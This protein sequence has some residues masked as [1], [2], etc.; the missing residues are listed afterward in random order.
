MAFFSYDASL[1][2]HIELALSP[3][4]LSNYKNAVGGDL[5]RA[6]DLYCWNVA[7]GAA[8]FG[9]L[10][11]LEV[12][13]LNALDL[14]L[15]T[16]FSEPWYDDPTFRVVDA[17]MNSRID[18]AKSEIL[19]RGRTVT[20]SRVI[21]ELSFGFWV[22]MLRPGPKGA[23]VRTLWGPAISR[24][25]PRGLNRANVLLLFD[26]LLRFR[27]RVAHHEP[28]FASDLNAQYAGVLAAINLLAPA[29][30]PWVEHHARVHEL[31]ISGPWPALARY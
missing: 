11:V 24:A 15:S 9:P 25:F 10:G 14:Q 28:I 29:L 4:R 19:K 6:V 16:V 26:P 12:V 13:F 22:Q 7:V 18:E 27:N 23:Y 21:A 2:Q 30:V 17:K 1:N 3:N 20:H 8:F 5:Q 31:V